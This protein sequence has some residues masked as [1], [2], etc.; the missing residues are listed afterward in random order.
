MFFFFKF[1]LCDVL[2][3]WTNKSNDT[4]IVELMHIKKI[5]QVEINILKLTKNQHAVIF[6]LQEMKDVTKSY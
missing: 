5:H 2:I 1:F 3:L 4:C 6:M